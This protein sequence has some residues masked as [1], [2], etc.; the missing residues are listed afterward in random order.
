MWTQEQ[1]HEAKILITIES[2]AM[3]ICKLNSKFYS[4]VA[5]HD[6]MLKC[7]C[8]HSKREKITTPINF[9]NRSVFSK[10]HPINKTIPKPK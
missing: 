1:M 3:E 4:G 9:I 2:L 10:L 6:I 7:E 5:K 8:C